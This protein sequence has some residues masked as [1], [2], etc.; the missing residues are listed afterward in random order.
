MI[1]GVVLIQTILAFG[2]NCPLVSDI[3]SNQFDTQRTWKG[4]FGKSVKI[5]IL[6]DQGLGENSQKVMGMVKQWG[7]DLM[8]HVGDYDYL[9]SPDFFMDQ[10][11]GSMGKRF[12]MLS[13][14]GNHDLLRWFDVGG[15]RDLLQ[16]QAIKSGVDR[17]CA[18]EFGVNRY[19]YL[20]NMIFV[21][22]GVGTLGRDHVEFID[23][24]FTRF[25]HVPWK[26]CIWHKN[27]SKLQ[28]G[29]KKDETG[30][31]VYGIRV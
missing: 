11:E 27:Q 7:A 19:C 5:A 24:T 12:K 31:G 21:L 20:D 3:K 29:D 22:S 1:I 16:K 6:G 23:E 10:F 26:F 28:T 14:P 17:H 8:V 15:Y 9:D 18:G 25:A 13:V 30:Y 4:I 2:S